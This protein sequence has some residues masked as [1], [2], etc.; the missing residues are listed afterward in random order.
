[1]VLRYNTL[2]ELKLLLQGKTILWEIDFLFSDKEIYTF[3]LLVLNRY[4]FLISL[5]IIN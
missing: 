5:L 1:M 2:E 3:A 4:K